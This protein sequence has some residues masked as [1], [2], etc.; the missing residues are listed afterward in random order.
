MSDKISAMELPALDTRH[1]MKGIYRAIAFVAIY[2]FLR[3]LP[4]PHAF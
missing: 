2:H 4:Q 1:W 3:W